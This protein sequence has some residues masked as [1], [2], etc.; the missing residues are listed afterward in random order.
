MP[1]P[2]FVERKASCA[3]WKQR[4][5]EKLPKCDLSHNTLSSISNVR[6]GVLCSATRT[7]K[8]STTVSLARNRHILRSTHGCGR[9]SLMDTVIIVGGVA[10][11]GEGP[12]ERVGP[13]TRVFPI[14][15]R[16]LPPGEGEVIE[17][18]RDD[19][20][21]T[22]GAI[23]GLAGIRRVWARRAQHGSRRNGKQRFAFEWSFGQR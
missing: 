3:V 5:V 10:A 15:T 13:R 23:A 4:H 20:D 19:H 11:G 14:Q 2:F 16:A 6:L 17:G 8:G 21:R 12:G 7:D 1:T 22:L 18:G 9:A